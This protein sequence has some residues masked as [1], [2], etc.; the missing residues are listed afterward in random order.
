MTCSA[1]RVKKCGTDLIMIKG[2][3]FMHVVWTTVELRYQL[4]S[5]YV[6]GIGPYAIYTSK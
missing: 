2:R 4:I 1:A 5:L 6:C 3:V